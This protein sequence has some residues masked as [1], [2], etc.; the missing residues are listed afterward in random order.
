MKKIERAILQVVVA[1]G[2]SSVVVQL[3]TIRE[4]LAQF[5]GNEFIIALILFCW[6]TLGGIGT[7]LAR[8]VAQRMRAS[9][10]AL[11][12]LSFLLATLA[13]IQILAIR[14]LRDFFF[15]HGTSVGFYQTLA[16]IGLLITPYCLLLGYVLPY[17]L[18]VLRHE[19]PDYPGARIYITDNLGDV[20]GGALFAFILVFWATPLQAVLIANIPLMAATY[21][22]YISRPKSGAIILAVAA[23]GAMAFGI[24]WEKQSLVPSE[25]RLVHYQE[26]RYGRISVHQD[27]EQYTLFKDNL[28][29]FSS[30][31]IA[32][33]EE[34]IH[35]PLS[36]LLKARHTL[37]ISGEGGIMAEIEKYHPETVDYVELDPK[38]AAVQFQFNLMQPIDGLNVIHEDGRAHLKQTTAR[39]D[40]IILNLPEPDTFQVN[41]FYTDQFFRLAQ[42]HLNPE[43]IL[44]FSM[45]GF[46]NYLAEA[47]RQ[48]LSSLHNT[49]AR[50]FKNI[51]LL[52]GQRIFF[53]C[54]N[55]PIDWDIPALLEHRNIHTRY[56]R[57]YYY[58]NVTR[59][60]VDQLNALMDPLAPI[61]RDESPRLIKIMFSQ[62]FDKFATSPVAFMLVIATV[63]LVYVARMTRAEY[64]LFSTGFMTMGSEI[65]VIFA[66]QIFFGYI[67]FQ[68]GL[69]VTVFLA[70][71]LPGAWIGQKQIR[72]LKATLITADGI[73]ISLTAVLIIMVMTL[74]DR[75]PAPGYLIFGFLV[76]LACGFQFPVALQ[77]EGAG[78]GAVTR[79]F[80]ADLIGA[81]GGTLI[82]SVVLI[83]H[84]GI[85][86]AA[87]AL[88]A[89]KLSS[90]VILG[91]GHADNES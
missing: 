36:Q 7:L 42:T 3:I 32:T 26:S 80:S 56:I 24:V 52:P 72:H 22:L 78:A 91:G 90:L 10:N 43:G 82:T 48:K 37:L 77:L 81:A 9:M 47:Q 59:E 16:Y 27:Q 35:Y 44:S 62:W 58:G 63:S 65:I 40:A 33:A 55:A 18:F 2:I 76:S 50:H 23:T 88:I 87:A 14:F 67:Y 11:G 54:R 69:I 57:G 85:L 66:F 51:L 84:L 75:L 73:L 8:Q 21:L 46:D 25:G 53:L 38:I 45:Q 70:G 71:L 61:N 74:G 1:T 83:P 20:A 64:V 5:Q 79:T 39:Y 17:S 49:A 68:I 4:F 34:A 89:L 15:I 29:V 30:Q 12:I 60:R 6:L 19:I 13:P 86:W 28:P 41:R 31:N